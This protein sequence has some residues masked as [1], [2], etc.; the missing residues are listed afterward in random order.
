M[1]KHLQ[2]WRD[3]GFNTEGFVLTLPA[4]DATT[5]VFQGQS[6]AMHPSPEDEEIERSK[7]LYRVSIPDRKEWDSYV[8]RL[9]EETLRALG[10]TFS[11]EEPSSR[12]SPAPSMMS[13]QASSQSSALLISPPLN[14]SSMPL[15]SLGRPV[16]LDGGLPGKP[17]VAHFPRYSTTL[18]HGEKTL[19]NAGQIPV[20]Q[21]PI[22][23]NISPLGYLSQPS[24][25]ISSPQSSE[26]LAIPYN[27]SISPSPRMMSN[28]DQGPA[29][30][31]LLRSSTQSLQQPMQLLTQQPD[32]QGRGFPDAIESQERRNARKHVQNDILNPVP[33]G[34]HQNPSATLQME[35]EEAEAYLEEQDL[36]A[37]ELEKNQI[38][39]RLTLNRD[40]NTLPP[41]GT[42]MAEEATPSQS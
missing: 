22:H 5:Y 4:E 6:R 23:R 20:S 24:S 13:R 14:P 37:S 32:I 11:D 28:G 1:D 10:V 35:V 17:S 30:R 40:N 7:H 42:K 34:H 31:D 3:A 29:R 41:T 39:D 18:P 38:K 36:K 33:R 16:R 21:S 27:T 8:E 2:E 19:A 26:Q 25:R 9:K 12:K 15:N